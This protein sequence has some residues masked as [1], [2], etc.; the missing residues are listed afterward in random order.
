MGEKD[1]RVLFDSFA[2]EYDALQKQNLSVFG[3]DLA[4]FAHYKVKMLHNICNDIAPKSIL[5]FGCG[6]GRNIPSAT[7]YF[8][9]TKIYGCDTS[10]KSIELATTH[11]PDAHY[12]LISHPGDLHKNYPQK[13]DVIFMACVLHHIDEEERLNWLE[14]LFASLKPR[15]KPVIF[16]HN[17]FNPLTW[18][19]FNTCPYDAGAKLIPLHLAKKLLRSSGFTD[20]ALTYT[21]FFLWRTPFLEKAESMLRW[22]P[23]G[24]Q[25]C[26]AARKR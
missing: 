9:D 2:E 21:L 15:G 10:Q 17:P 12:S 8:P 3:K 20:I 13:L 5:E 7:K 19:I 23:L 24:G 25:Y 14:V 18:R 11:A 26:V 1:K 22:L 6:V 16:E 4:V